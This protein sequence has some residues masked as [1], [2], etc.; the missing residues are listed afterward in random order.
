MTVTYLA[1]EPTVTVSAKAGDVADTV[2]VTEVVS[3]SMLGVKE[4]D[5]KAV[6]V[7]NV[8]KEID[9]SKQV[10]L[11]DGVAKA[12][13]TQSNPGSAAAASVAFSVKSIAGP[14]I[15]TNAL[16]E[17]VA[18][19]K[20]GEIKTQLGALPGVTSVEVSYSPFWVHSTP[21]NT[22]KITVQI[23]KANTGKQ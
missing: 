23:D 22:S 21:K 11:D 5:L 7:A 12:K 8:N 2:T 16:R 13:F 20:S 18:G 15:D 3:Y 9:K 6:V 1:G 4:S 14:D 10:I 17:Q 19:K